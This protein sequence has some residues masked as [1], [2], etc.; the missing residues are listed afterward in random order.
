MDQGI[1]VEPKR[2]TRGVVIASTMVGAMGGVLPFLYGAIPGAIYGLLAGVVWKR[3][4]RRRLSSSPKRIVL[5]G[6]LW[7]G[8]LGL[9]AGTL[10]HGTMLVFL[11]ATGSLYYPNRHF[12]PDFTFQIWAF[13]ATLG[14]PIGLVAGFLL[15]LVL[16]YY[17]KSTQQPQPPSEHTAFA[18][19]VM[20]AS[21]V[22]GAAGGIFP[23]SW[24][25]VVGGVWGMIVGAL[26]V[27]IMMRR[28][29]ASAPLLWAGVGWGG[30]MGIL[31][32]VLL[33]GTMFLLLWTGAL[34]TNDRDWPVMWRVV[35]SIGIPCGLVAGLFLGALCG[36]A[37]ED[38]S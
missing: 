31:A 16:G 17:L 26:W 29:H 13:S 27:R 12:P 33:H 11:W 19:G 21:T 24:G 9:L 18:A 38:V 15:G 32:A 35:A 23:L 22:I 4:M 7:G 14:L 34:P 8:F 6:G 10:L 2:F 20:T 3:I 25:A 1:A 30:V 36:R 28:V 5:L 37:I